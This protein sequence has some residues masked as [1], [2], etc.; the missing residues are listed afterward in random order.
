M[1]RLGLLLDTLEVELAV[2]TIAVGIVNTMFGSIDLKN[3]QYI[4]CNRSLSFKLH[5]TTRTKT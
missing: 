5:Y 4:T 3:L 2:S 1:I